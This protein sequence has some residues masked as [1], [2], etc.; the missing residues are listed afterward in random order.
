MSSLSLSS[1]KDGGA[2]TVAERRRIRRMARKVA[3]AV[4]TRV[5]WEALALG[6]LAGGPMT[7]RELL[8]VIAPKW[9]GAQQKA[10]ADAVRRLQ[11]KGKVRE[12][13]M[14]EPEPHNQASCAM[15]SA[16]W[17]MTP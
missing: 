8:D 9:G 2:L 7:R 6:E 5:S 13:P 3:T 4:Q 12:R 10:M 1:Q 15:R 11:A 17:G 16:R 14:I